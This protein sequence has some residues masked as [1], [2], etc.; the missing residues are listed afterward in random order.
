MNKCMSVSDSTR[1]GALTAQRLLDA[2]TDFGEPITQAPG[3]FTAWLS[4]SKPRGL[5]N[6]MLRD[7]GLLRADVEYAVGARFWQD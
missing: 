2:V 1:A 3:M 5:D 6:H 7:L 4:R